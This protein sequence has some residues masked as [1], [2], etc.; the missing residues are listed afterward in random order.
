MKKTTNPDRKLRDVLQVA[1]LF[2]VTALTSA[3]AAASYIQTNLVSDVSGLAAFTDPNLVNPWGLS[4][5]STSP[6]WLSDNGTGVSTLYNGNTGQPASLVVTIPSPA[7]SP[8]GTKSTP[9]GQVFNGSSGFEIQP[10]A[11][12]RFLFVTQDGTLSG[13]NPAANLTS[14]VLKVDNS[15]SGAAY[16]GL[17]LSGNFLYVANFSGGRIDV[18]DTTF[19]PTTLAGG[20]TDPNLPAGYVPFNIQNLGGELYVTY[21]QVDSNGDEITGAGLG[22]V[23][24]FDADGNLLRRVATGG[25]LN[26]PWG[27]ALAPSDFGE[28][29]G[30]LLVGNFGDGL[31]NALD[32]VTGQLL[33][34]VADG[35]NNPIAIDGLWGIGFG[36]DGNAGRH[37]VLFFAAGIER[38]THGLFGSI[39]ATT[40]S[41]VPEPGTL[42]LVAGIVPLLIWYGRRSRRLRAAV[43]T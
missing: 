8:A 27:L 19:A 5:S 26:A 23:D 38:E 36:N 1:G 40:P 2:V 18:F 13:W 33:G 32:P 37:N 22:I 28:F 10:G 17:A 42:G 14:A 31:I 35:L 25:A 11:P 29:S 34:Q 39:A 6:W 7:G 12:A 20:F 30:D 21:A 3:P 9:T 43:L 16:T 41:A 24:V 4:S 15:A